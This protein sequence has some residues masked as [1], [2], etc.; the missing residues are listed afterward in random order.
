MNKQIRI[1]IADD[2]KLIRETW[3][4]LLNLDNRFKVIGECKNGIE[5]VEKAF[6]LKP[7]IILMDINMPEINGFDA[8]K[9]IK[10]KIP[11]M[12]IIGIS[13]HALPAYAKKLMMMGANGYVTKNSSREE[14]IT[15][16]LTVIGGRQYICEE[17]KDL[18][19]DQ[20]DNETVLR[21]N[22]KTLT[23]KEVAVVKYIKQGLTSKELAAK[24]EVSVKTI[25]THRYNILK[26]L[27]QKNINAVIH[28]LQ[29]N[30]VE[31]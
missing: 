29:E 15:A 26:K 10:A 23:D 19:T 7:D 9:Q 6:L 22:L 27:D 13:M 5:C 3:T 2:H 31:I 14:M 4:F 24:L 30:G 25:E 21:L 20:E 17:I 28:L 8:T 12:K 1:I 11:E 18:I 16:I